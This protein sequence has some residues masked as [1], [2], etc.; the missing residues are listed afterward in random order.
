MSN[1]VVINVQPRTSYQ[2]VD[3]EKKHLC[4]CE[5]GLKKNL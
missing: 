2:Q 4:M 1:E 3:I 5:R